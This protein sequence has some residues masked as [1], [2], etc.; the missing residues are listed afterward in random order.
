MPQY[1]DDSSSQ[2]VEVDMSGTGS[3]RSAEEFDPAL[4]VWG[5][6]DRQPRFLHTMIRVREFEP[7]LRFYIDG[8]GMKV[9]SRFSVPVRRVDAMF[10]GYADFAQGGML[11][12]VRLWDHQGPH[13]HG[14]GYGHISVS[15]PDLEATLAKLV[16]MGVEVIT[17]PTVLLAGGPKVAFVKDFDGYAIELI[18]TSRR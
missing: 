11:E 9:L 15:A 2:E 1:V 10:I 14:S 6:E 4:W 18:Q 16:G 17:P 3:G 5:S 8:L 12:L 13:T 7:A